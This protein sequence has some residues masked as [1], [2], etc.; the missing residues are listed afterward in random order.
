MRTPKDAIRGGRL[1]VAAVKLLPRQL[2]DALPVADRSLPPH[3]RKSS[4]RCAS[5]IGTVS[6]AGALPWPFR[7]NCCCQM[8]ASWYSVQWDVASE[9]IPAV[10]LDDWAV[11]KGH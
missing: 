2:R 9:T 8:C 6:D 3:N 5:C 11:E 7:S 4:I 1:P 10:S